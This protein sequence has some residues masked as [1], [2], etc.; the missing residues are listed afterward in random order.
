MIWQI[1]WQRLLLVAVHI[2]VVK[3]AHILNIWTLLWVYHSLSHSVCYSGCL[4]TVCTQL[5]LTGTLALL[6]SSFCWGHLANHFPKDIRE[7][8]RL[9]LQLALTMSSSHFLSLFAPLPE[10]KVK[11]LK[12]IT[13]YGGACS[14]PLANWVLSN[15]WVITWMQTGVSLYL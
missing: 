15:I 13:K 8:T 11:R 2:Q 7:K 12:R 5:P 9:P 6:L 3:M 1:K 14:S 4:Y 10:V